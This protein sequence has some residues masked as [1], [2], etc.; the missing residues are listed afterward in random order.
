MMNTI[1][2]GFMEK[3][4]I[5]ETN[6]SHLIIRISEIIRIEE[7][8][9]GSVLFLSN[10]KKMEAAEDLD[11]WATKLIKHPFIMVHDSHLLNLNAIESYDLQDKPSV[12]LSNGEHIEVQDKYK[13]MLKEVFNDYLEK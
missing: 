10:N 9:K 8:G 5:L 7:G 11:F 2:P 4:I 13:I 1:N 3:K 12:T 6:D